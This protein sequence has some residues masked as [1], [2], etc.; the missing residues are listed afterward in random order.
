VHQ[1]G[2][3]HRVPGLFRAQTAPGNPSQLRVCLVDDR[4]QSALVALAPSEKKLGQFLRKVL[5]QI[6]APC[7][8]KL[9]PS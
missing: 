7:V 5:A 4:F 6:I 3:V 9:Y 8:A 1:D 2:G